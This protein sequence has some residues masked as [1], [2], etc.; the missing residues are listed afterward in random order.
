MP[1][2]KLIFQQF[3]AMIVGLSLN[4]MGLLVRSWSLIVSHWLFCV[5]HQIYLSACDACLEVV[6]DFK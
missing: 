3:S 6:F 5:Q 2:Q 1:F 4:S